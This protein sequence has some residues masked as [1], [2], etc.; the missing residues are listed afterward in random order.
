MTCAQCGKPASRKF[1]SR[2]CF[3][4]SRVGVPRPEMRKRRMLQCAACGTSVEVGG[5]AE[6]RGAL[7]FCS[8]TCAAA[9]R[10]R[11][12]SKSSAL[13]QVQSAYLAGLI[14]GEGS[15]ILYRRGSGSAMRLTITSTFR[16]VL[17]W[18]Q[19]LCGVGNIVDVTSRN[20]KHKQQRCWLVNSQ[21]AQSVLEQVEPYMIIKREQAQLAIE[22]QKRLK[23]PAEKAQKEWQEQWRQRLRAMN[24]RGPV[25]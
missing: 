24:A 12:G 15:I 17:E 7:A 25:S 16:P 21:A 2:E 5:R 23:T 11:T 9:A 1:C 10:W 22:F 3:Y 14:D 13:T 18:C 19:S 6:H 4:R 8:R 20:A